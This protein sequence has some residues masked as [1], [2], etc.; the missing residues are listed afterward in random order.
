MVKVFRAIKYHC[1]CFF[2]IVVVAGLVSACGGLSVKEQKKQVQAR[3]TNANEIAEPVIAAFDDNPDIESMTMQELRILRSSVYARHGMLFNESDLRNY[4]KEN[5]VWYD[6]LSYSQYKKMNL[7]GATPTI[8]LPDNEQ[9]LVDR[10]DN[11]MLQL[12][13]ANYIYTGYDTIVN[14]LNVVNMFQYREITRQETMD[15]LAFD[16]YSCVEDTIQQLFQVYQRNDSLQLPNFVTTDLLLQLSHVYEAYVLRTIEQEYYA[17]MF[18]ELCLSLYNASIVQANKATKEEIKDIAAYNAAFY[19]IPYIL[20]SGKQLKIAG[21]YQTAVE[22]EL[23]YIA[24]Q[25]DHRPAL[26]ELKADFPYSAFKL[27]GHYTRTAEL[28][29]YFK[30]FKWLQLAPYCQSNKMQLQQAIFAAIILNSAK[31]QSGKPALDIYTRL[32]ESMIWFIGQPACNSILDIADFLKK[33]RITSVSDAT[34]AKVLAKV[35]AMLKKAFPEGQ[36]VAK[37]TMDCRDGIY[38]LPQPY[39][40]DEEVLQTMVDRTKSANWAFPKVLDVFAAFGSQPAFNKLFI[41]ER[42][43]TIWT[44]YPESLARMT[45][46]MHGFKYWN[47]SSYYKRLE[48]LLAMQQ[49]LQRSPFVQKQLWNRKRLETASAGWVKLKHDM[50]LYGVIPEYPEPLDTTSIIIDSLPQPITVGFVEPDLLFWGNLLEWV[51]LTDKTLKKHQLSNDRINNYTAC[52]HRYVAFMKEAS[53]KELSNERLTDEAYRFIAHIGDS[54]QQF[55]LSMIEPQVDRWAWVAGVDRSVAVFDEIY[56]RNI[57]DCSKNGILYAAT[58]NVNN[59]YVIVEIGGFLY[60]TK[61]A[62]FSYDEFNMPEGKVLKEN[63]WLNILKNKMIE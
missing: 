9:A 29:R 58:G 44:A 10:I 14:I 62:T 21:E 28:R 25:E 61:G 63:D 40:P 18:A 16:Q 47:G 49:R 60:L 33:E 7:D 48:C 59:I 39:Y 54:I 51:E 24:Q 26:L 4:W 30:A 3:L 1:Q 42:E 2:I 43:D 56:Q 12:Q 32:F 13:Q 27:Y 11:R 38:F 45:D 53:S 41:D 52:M 50:L 31:T 55:T 15:E 8:V 57:T 34:D 20:V 46:K 37:Y 35:D 23:A 36:S 5:A 6:T 17:P 19:A 22:E